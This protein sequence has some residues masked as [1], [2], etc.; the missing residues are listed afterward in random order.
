MDIV[1]DFRSLVTLGFFIMF[2]GI[3]A[4]A[5]SARNRAAFDEAA[6]LPFGDDEPLKTP[7]GGTRE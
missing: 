2:L 6:A 5:Y 1:N 3:V 7:I 4:W